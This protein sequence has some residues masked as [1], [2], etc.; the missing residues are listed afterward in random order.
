MIDA[1]TG[2]HLWAE[3][4]DG[5]LKDIFNLQDEITKKIVTALQVKL[6]DGEQARMWSKKTKNLDFYLK[7]MEGHAACREGTVEGHIKEAQISQELIDMEPESPLGYLGLGHSY[8]YL[9][10]AGIS[11]QENLKKAFKLTQKALAMDESS[12]SAHAILGSIYLRMRKHEMAIAAGKRSIELDPNGAL[13]HGFLGITLSYAGRPDEAIGYINKGI[14]LNP[15]PEYWYFT[16]L[17]RCYILKGQYEDALTA[18]KKALHRNPDAIDN[19]IIL[20]LI[21]ALLDRQEEAEAS[22]KK[23]LEMMPILSVGLMSKISP[24][25]NQTDLKL[26]IDALRKAGFPERA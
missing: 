16:Q 7:R 14:R 19:Y 13:V 9:A 8:W 1:I 25:K 20:A 12:A 11:P 6:T 22:V 24:F 26:F 15:F 17:S 2:H 3:R 5:D 21:Y 23:A 4:Y 10:A 18:T